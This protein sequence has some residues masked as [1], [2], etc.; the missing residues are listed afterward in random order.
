MRPLL[1]PLPIACGVCRI[2]CRLLRQLLQHRPVGRV[3]SAGRRAVTTVAG[4]QDGAEHAQL[5]ALRSA[6]YRGY[7]RQVVSCYGSMWIDVAHNQA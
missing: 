1:V 2:V 7:D 6:R 3:A 5:V 4:A